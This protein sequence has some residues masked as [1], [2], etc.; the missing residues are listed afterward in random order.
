[1]KTS[2]F[3]S[4]KLAI[5]GLVVFVAVVFTSCAPG[6]HTYNDR[7]YGN[8][9]HYPGYYNYG[10]YPGY[11]G[12]GYPRYS[13]RYYYNDYYRQRSAR[14][15]R[16]DRRR[17]TSDSREN[18][19]SRSYTPRTTPPSRSYSTPRSTSPSRIYSPPSRSNSSRSYSPPSR[20]SSRRN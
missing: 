12:Y 11:Y 13:N 5:I 16:T 14:N 8:R 17:V 19:S 15:Y 7:Y 9:S 10:Y 20:G 6:Y 18:R 1:M 2:F 3:N 4:T